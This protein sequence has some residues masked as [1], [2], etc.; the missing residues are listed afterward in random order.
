MRCRRDHRDL[1]PAERARYVAALYDAKARGVVDAFADEHQVHFSHGHSH[2]SF[3][4]WHR[5]FIRRFEVELQTYDRRV[6]LCYWNSSDDQSTTSALWSAN[7]LGQFNSA[8]SLGRSLGGGSLPSPAAVQAALN[9][10]TYDVCQLSPQG[11]QSISPE[12]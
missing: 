1:T 12:G 7:F 9:Q 3:L 5:E 6:M 11:C 4:P 10:P 2:S 8:W